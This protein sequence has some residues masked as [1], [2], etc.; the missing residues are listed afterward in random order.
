MCRARNQ[1]RCASFRHPAARRTAHL[2]CALIRIIAVIV[3]VSGAFLVDIGAGM[4]SDHAQANSRE[5]APASPAQVYRLA[6]LSCHDSDGR[7]ERARDAL[8]TIPD[9][10]NLGWH[11]SRADEDLE[12]SILHGKGRAMRPMK[13]KL[14]SL[15]VMQMVSFVRGFR[16]GGVVV[17]EEEPPSA[18]PTDDTPPGTDA[19]STAVPAVQPP[20]HERAPTPVGPAQPPRS[21]QTAA[22][23]RRLCTAC[24]GP[25]GR[26]SDVRSALTTLPDFSNHQW[27]MERNDAEMTAS[28][29]DG[30][31]ASMPAWRGRL[32]VDQARELA[33]F[34]RTLDPA[35]LVASVAP[36]GDFHRRFHALREQWEELDRQVKALDRRTNAVNR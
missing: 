36:A 24:H 34:V 32:S 23:F 26:G 28:I 16:G 25:D 2:A 5:A 33:A 17:R 12:R 35:G 9:F 11:D 6:C 10:T 8:P 18:A 1:N 22:L 4:A 3:L 15:S 7:G 14:G 31:G 27:Q 13:K 19:V 20:S 21:N 30:K 29:L